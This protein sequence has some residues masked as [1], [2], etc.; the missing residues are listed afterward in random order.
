MKRNEIIKGLGE[1]E[2][3]LGDLQMDALVL[4][5]ALINGRRRGKKKNGRQTKT[6]KK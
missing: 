3:K 5:C 6:S 2:K 1:L 4:R